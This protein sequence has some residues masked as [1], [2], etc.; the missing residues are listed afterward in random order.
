MPNYQVKA[1]AYLL[2]YPQCDEPMTDMCDRIEEKWRD[3]LNFC[4]VSD[5]LHEDGNHHRHVYLAFKEQT[6]F[7][8]ANWAD[9]ICG[10]HGNYK[11]IKWSLKDRQRAV[12]YVKKDKRYVLFRV[13]EEEL[14]KYLASPKGQETQ[15]IA[16]ALIAG[17]PINDLMIKYPAFMLRNLQ[18]VKAFAAQASLVRDSIKHKEFLAVTWSPCKCGDCDPSLLDESAVTTAVEIKEWFNKAITMFKAGTTPFRQKQLWLI[19]LPGIGKSTLFQK[20]EESLRI[21]DVPKDENFY[22]FYSD[23]EWDI[24]LLDEFG[25]QKTIYWMNS[26][27]DGSKL[28]LRVK[29]AQVRKTDRLPT[30]IISNAHPATLYRS[31]IEKNADCLTPLVGSPESRCVLYHVT[32]EIMHGFGVSDRPARR[33]ASTSVAELEE[34]EASGSLSPTQ[35]MDSGD[36][37]D[38]DLECDESMEESEE[39]EDLLMGG[40]MQSWDDD[41]SQSM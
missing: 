28:T 39:E 32:K 15:N 4:I 7:T 8:R 10:K 24:A 40:E 5:E 35:E 29:G 20:L 22:D 27:L 30:V 36:E 13:T 12:A 34:E 33:P 6:R 25:G 18:K 37:A 14:E 19:G 26:W 17:A 38:L 21:Y 2:T 11:A 1:K 3:S 23:K 41:Y 9:F 31:A 16:E